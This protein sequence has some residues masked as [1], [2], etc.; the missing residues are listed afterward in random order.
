MSTARLQ[1]VEAD[2]R[3]LRRYL[4]EASQ[5]EL[6]PAL[7]R[8]PSPPLI[9]SVEEGTEVNAARL[10]READLRTPWQSGPG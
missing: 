9:R 6:F 8:E 3:R 7:A 1:Q 10:A 2:R 4:A 5:R